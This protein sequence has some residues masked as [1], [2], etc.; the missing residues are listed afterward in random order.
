M[1][2]RQVRFCK[3]ILSPELFLLS[4]FLYSKIV[5]EEKK[6]PHGESMIAL[7]KEGTWD[8]DFL[9]LRKSHTESSVASHHSHCN[10]LLKI[11][12]L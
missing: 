10:L 9:L 11:C 7:A 2:L 4:A 3:S 6:T 12:V 5:L 1:S 8:E